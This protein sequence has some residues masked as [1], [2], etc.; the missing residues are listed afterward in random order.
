MV[1]RVVPGTVTRVEE[2]GLYLSFG[3]REVVV[4]RPDVT[5]RGADDRQKHA[6]G[7]P[8]AVTRCLRC[9]PTGWR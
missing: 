2:Y 9:S 4:L 7:R 3:D 6:I 5:E 8:C 1:G